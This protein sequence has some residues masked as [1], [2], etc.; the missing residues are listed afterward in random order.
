VGDVK[1]LNQDMDAKNLQSVYVFTGEE[2]GLISQYVNDIKSRF[3]NVVETDDV[4]LVIEDC[5]YNPIFGGGKLY[6]LRE[7]GLFQKQVDDKFVNF[8]VKMFKQK[9]NI[10]IFVESAVDGKF[11]QVQALGDKGLINF[12]RLSEDQLIGFVTQIL[13]NNNKKMLKDLT[14]YFVDQ[15]DYDYNTIIN[16]IT[17]LLNYTDAK[18]IKVDDVKKVVTQSS[19]SIVFD[20]VDYIVKQ[21]Y[22]RAID[23]FYMLLNKKEQPLVI[24]TLIY[25]QLR[26]LYQIKLLKAEGHNVNDI[27]DACDSKPFIIEKSMNICN[28][29]TD[30]LL[31]LMVKCSDMD[32][33]IKTGQI[34]DTLAIECL[35]LY[36]SIRTL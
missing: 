23:M 10:C 11:K 18:E 1:S 6:I 3:K 20:L 28:F 8:L 5:K 22:Q 33:K 9:I 7:T 13:A 36:S 2:Q 17:K 31:K 15:C 34:K 14:R 35:I 29:D 16:E 12:K 26:L 24:L 4:D 32:W 30:K 21:Q 25:R 19:R 27:A